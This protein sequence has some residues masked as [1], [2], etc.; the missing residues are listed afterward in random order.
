MKNPKACGARRIVLDQVTTVGQV[1]LLA[2]DQ[3]QSGHVSVNGLDIIAAD[4]LNRPEHP[5]K[6]GVDVPPGAFT[7]WNLQPNVDWWIAEAEINSHGP[8]GIGFVNFGTIHILRVERTIET[9][10]RG[11]RGFNAYDGVMD[12]AS[13]SAL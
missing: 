3:V 8:S 13:L 2:R 12:T 11:A 7:L 6:Y 9:F 10:G 4:A 5:H 1:Q